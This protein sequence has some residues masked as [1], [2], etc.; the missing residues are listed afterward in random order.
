MK[1]EV[2]S[3]VLSFL[4]IINSIMLA[5]VII[6]LINIGKINLPF[7]DNKI[8]NFTDCENLSLFET[9]SCLV[10][11]VRPFYNYT[12]RADTSKSLDDIK[13]NGGDC[14]DYSNLYKTMANTLDYKSNVI[15][16]VG[17]EVNHDFVVIWDENLTG[18]CIIDQLFSKCIHLEQQNKTSIRIS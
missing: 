6:Y 16:L 1:I 10:N 12:I 14:Y 3:R 4:L 5:L 17:D 8:E 15:K 18:Y 9:S 11:Y 7:S 13:Q 2:D